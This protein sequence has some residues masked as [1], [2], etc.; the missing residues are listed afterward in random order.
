MHCS[1][2]KH[3]RKGTGMKQ[4]RMMRN[5]APLIMPCASGLKRRGGQRS[6]GTLWA[7]PGPV[8][9]TTHMGRRKA[10]LRSSPKRR[11]AKK[12]SLKAGISVSVATKPSSDPPRL[13]RRGATGQAAIA[14]A[15]AGPEGHGASLPAPCWPDARVGGT[16]Y[17]HVFSARSVRGAPSLALAMAASRCYLCSA[18]AH[19]TSSFLP[20]SQHPAV[21]G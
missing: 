3:R 7:G 12:W 21:G 19:I 14:A 5:T 1:S 10:L 8:G 9:T 16:G 17:A 2:T 20:P 15:G 18:V 4:N 13:M 6:A 11:A